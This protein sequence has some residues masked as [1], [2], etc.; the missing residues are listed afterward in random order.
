MLQ[1]DSATST[2]ASTEHNP[3]S[4]AIVECT[5]Q[6]VSDMLC[7]FRAHDDDGID[8]DD[9]WSGIPA[10]AAFT[11]RAT[12]HT[13]SR[14]MPVQL[15][16]GR[17]AVL[18]VCHLANWQCICEQKQDSVDQS[19]VRENAK[20]LPHRHKPGDQA[21]IKAE[22]K[23]KFRTDAHLGPCVVD[24]VFDDGMLHMDEG[25]PSDVCNVCD[26]TPCLVQA[27]NC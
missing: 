7:T 15:V 1:E 10:A 13:T 23:R 9:P 4:N 26:I 14:A 2:S 19:N 8:Q 17:N 18:N 6:T 27:R 16:F 21:L 25:G 20:C 5:H 22:Q 12:V 11:A 24:H 3:Q